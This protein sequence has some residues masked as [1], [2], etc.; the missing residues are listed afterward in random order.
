MT[1]T[2]RTR[3][4][5]AARELTSKVNSGI[6][7]PEILKDLNLDLGSNHVY[8]LKGPLEKDPGKAEGEMFSYMVSGVSLL[9]CADKEVEN[10]LKECGYGEYLKVIL[11]PNSL[12]VLDVIK[13]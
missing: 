13:Q 7:D 1:D 4:E 6:L 10:M 5:E 3:I 8:T 2:Y 12:I 9:A 11:A